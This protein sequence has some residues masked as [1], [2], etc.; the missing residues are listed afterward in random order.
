MFIYIRQY[1]FYVNHKLSKP[2]ELYKN[3]P[4]FNE[5]SIIFITIIAYNLAKL[6]QVQFKGATCSFLYIRLTQLLYSS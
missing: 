4:V 6:Y 1:S 3:V 5:R 2:H